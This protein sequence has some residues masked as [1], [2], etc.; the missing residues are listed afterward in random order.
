MALVKSIAGNEI[1]DQSVRDKLNVNKGLNTTTIDLRDTEKYSTDTYY[2]VVGTSIP[3]SG[4]HTFEV[5][6]QLT[7]NTAPS[8]STHNGKGFTCNVSVKMAAFGWGT[9][10]TD[11][12]GWIDTFSFHWCDKMPAYIQ[13]MGNSS[14]PV[15]YLRGGGCYYLYTDYY[16]TWSIKTDT[17][18]Y[19]N[20]SVAP[21][22]TPSNYQYLYNKYEHTRVK[23]TDDGNGNVT[24]SI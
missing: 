11:Q 20:Q 16:C 8:W 1:C 22:K 5:N 21:T 17:Y 14:A 24:I 2:P 15:F 13:Q 23:T 10:L 18:T 7:S 3:Y 9:V 6:N 19:Q 12:I 4:H